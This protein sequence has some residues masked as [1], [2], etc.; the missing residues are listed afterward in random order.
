MG[1]VRAAC[2]WVGVVGCNIVIAVGDSSFIK[3]SDMYNVISG[4]LEDLEVTLKQILNKNF[5]E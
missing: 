3:K 4:A 5:Y 1:V 2:T